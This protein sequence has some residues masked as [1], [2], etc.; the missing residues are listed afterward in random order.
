MR[1]EKRRFLPSLFRLVGYWRRRRKSIHPFN[2]RNFLVV[3]LNLK[4]IRCFLSS[5]NF[6]CFSLRGASVFDFVFSFSIYE[7]ER[8]Q[9]PTTSKNPSPANSSISRRDF[10]LIRRIILDMYES[11]PS[12]LLIFFN[13]R[14]FLIFFFDSELK[15][16][17]RFTFHL[18]I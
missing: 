2:R 5:L 14:S 12:L 4:L 6:R 8:K 10:E 16:R 17:K 13:Q 3:R 18:F 11:S 7:S 15:N 9:K 1:N